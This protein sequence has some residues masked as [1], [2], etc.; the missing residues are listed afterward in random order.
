MLTF[1]PTQQSTSPTPPSWNRNQHNEFGLPVL[2]RGYLP[3]SQNPV[4]QSEY[5]PWPLVTLS[6]VT[7]DSFRR[8]E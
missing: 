5:D 6:G 8:S 4:E 2:S 1:N 3:T 7:S